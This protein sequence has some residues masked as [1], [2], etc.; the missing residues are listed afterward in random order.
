VGNSLSEPLHERSDPYKTPVIGPISSFSDL[1]SLDS[2]G[3][4]TT[5]SVT[6]CSAGS[7]SVGVDGGNHLTGGFAY[8]AAG[9]LTQ[10]GTG[11]PSWTYSYDAENRLK[12]LRGSASATYTYDG[13]GQRTKMSNNGLFWRQPGGPILT[14]TRVGGAPC[15]LG[16]ERLNFMVQTI[17]IHDSDKN[18]LSFDLKDILRA[19][20]KNAETAEWYI[21]NLEGTGEPLRNAEPLLD[22]EKRIQSS[23]HGVKATWHTLNQLADRMV[24]TVNLSLVGLSP[25]EPAP[26]LPVQVAYGGLFVSIEAI[27]S[28]LWTVS[29]NDKQVIDCLRRQFRDTKLVRPA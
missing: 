21:L 5:E 27:D 11:T 18:V 1:H 16:N 6:K 2:W 10:E 26:S 12:T 8:D 17:E 22:L 7:L 24:Q 29:S 23:K 25:G 13:D 19:L 20:P 14:K 9:N 28:S 4:L 3:N 15:E